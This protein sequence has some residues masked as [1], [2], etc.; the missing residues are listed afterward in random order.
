MSWPEAEWDPESRPAGFT[1]DSK[2]C[3]SSGRKSS[4]HR[5]SSPTLPGP[6]AALELSLKWLEESLSGLE[7]RL[8]FHSHVSW[9]LVQSQSSESEALLISVVPNLGGPLAGTS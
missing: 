5:I 3:L 9:L 6:L 7:G 1:A 4:G 2:L 8:Q